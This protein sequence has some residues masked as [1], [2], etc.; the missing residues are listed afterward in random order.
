ML[1]AVWL[2][3]LL[4]ECRVKGVMGFCCSA[5]CFLLQMALFSVCLGLNVKNGVKYHI[6]NSLNVREKQS[7]G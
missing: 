2:L 7:T 4:S 3:R 1:R 6:G 5:F